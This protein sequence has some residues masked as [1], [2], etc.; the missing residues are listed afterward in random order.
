MDLDIR[1]GEAAEGGTARR[2]PDI[3][4][5]RGLGYSPAVSLD[6]GL[7]RTVA[8]YREHRDQVPANELM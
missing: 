2:C 3:T 6:E 4:T 8:W 7:V 5:M 1:P